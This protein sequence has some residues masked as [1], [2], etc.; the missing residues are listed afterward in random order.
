MNIRSM[1]AVLAAT[2]MLPLGAAHATDL[3]VT[4]WW[5]SGGEA[6]AV[7]ELA[8]AFN[9]TGNKWV[10][11]AIAGS[12]GTA[13]PIMIS[14]ITG[15]DPMA[16]TQ[17]NHGR[18]AEELVQAG[19]M[20]DFTDLAKK[21]GW[22][23][24]VRPAGLLKSCTFEGKI[25]CVPLNIHS[26]QWL[27]LSNDAFKKAGVA[28]PK[29]W[30][31]YVAAA[32]AL[33][34]AGIVPLA[35][36]GQ[37]WQSTGLFSVLTVAIGGKEIYQKVY[38]DKDAKVAAGPEMAKVFKAADDARK[39]SKGTNVQDWNQATNMVITGKA[40]GQIMGDWAQGE[41]Q[42]AGKKAGVDYTCLPGLG[43]NEI[44]ST[45]GDAF[46]FPV[47]KDAAK[48]KAQEVLASTLLDAKTQVA[49]NLK[50]GSLPVRGD[51]DLAA[52]ND[53]MKKG[54]EILAK[55][56]VVTSTDQLITQDTQKQLEDLM[57][58]FFANTS[59]TAEEA[60]KRFVAIFSKAG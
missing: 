26:W 60:Q 31:E 5:T 4:H 32:P 15:G 44:I 16:A 50:K 52:A 39:M 23:K 51:V 9:A 27:W 58:Q 19:L 8:K 35:I 53:C 30:D 55:G 28:V 56:N 11:G 24:I 13:R 57:S 47:L 20:R 41:F 33:E 29:N 17:F 59:I 48:T 21:E 2:V 43:V 25:Y 38:G 54:L 45:A 18:Q 7:A 6:A 12:G 14:R 3:E 10:D 46:Y 37:A 40:G 49:F 36:G 22:D 42:L 34:K 1:A